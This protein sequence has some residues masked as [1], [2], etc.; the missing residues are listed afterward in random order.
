M[1]T[2]VL[3][4]CVYKSLLCSLM[5]GSAVGG[6]LSIEVKFVPLDVDLKVDDNA[7]STPHESAGGT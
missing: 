7:H 6:T 3:Y 4:M 2:Y 5:A 1:F